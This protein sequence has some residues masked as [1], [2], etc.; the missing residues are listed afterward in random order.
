MESIFPFGKYSMCPVLYPT[1]E[2]EPE[3][4]PEEPEPIVEPEPEP[5]KNPLEDYSTSELWAEIKRRN[6]NIE[7]S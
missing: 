6:I 4:K 3:E 2:M 5:E 1:D 7:I